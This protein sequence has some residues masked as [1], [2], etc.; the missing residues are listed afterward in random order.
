MSVVCG[1]CLVMWLICGAEFKGTLKMK[2][3]MFGS[4]KD[5]WVELKG[6]KIRVKKDQNVCG[7]VGS[8]RSDMH[9]HS[10]THSHW[11]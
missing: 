5:R 3:G 9:R 2:E 11:C 7:A 1:C 6:N 8:M 4:W 10:K